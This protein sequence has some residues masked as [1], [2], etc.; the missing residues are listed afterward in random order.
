MFLCGM[1]GWS[2]WRSVSVRAEEADWFHLDQICTLQIN[3]LCCFM[4]VPSQ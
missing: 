3:P 1:D 4:M 2:P